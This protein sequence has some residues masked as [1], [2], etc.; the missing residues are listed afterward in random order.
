MHN[1]RWIRGVGRDVHC[2]TEDVLLWA[3]ARDD[4][5]TAHVCMSASLEV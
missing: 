2:W 1:A 3:L 4:A 5:A